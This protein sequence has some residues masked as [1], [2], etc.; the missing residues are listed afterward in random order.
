LLAQTAAYTSTTKLTALGWILVTLSVIS[1]ACLLVGLMTPVMAIV[2]TFG[3]AALA[4][5]G[6]FH[7]SVGLIVLAIAVA[8]LGP[9]AFSLDARMF[10]RREILLPNPRPPK[11]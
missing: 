7:F 9:G 6:L 4:V 1:A 2:V 11:A 8:L 5:S 10:G 3:A